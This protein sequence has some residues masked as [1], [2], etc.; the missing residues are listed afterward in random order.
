[1]NVRKEFSMKKRIFGKSRGQIAVL[2]AGII[3]VLLGAVALGADVAVMYVKWQQAQKVADVAAL[4]GANYLAGGVTYADST[5]GTAYPT[6]SGCNGES[7]G[8]TSAEIATQVA[9][10]YAV[11][12]GLPASTVTISEPASEIKVVATETGLPYFFAKTLGMSTYSVSA[13]A[14]AQAPGP[15][16]TVALSRGCSRL[17]SNALHHARRAA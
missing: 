7:S 1:V 17:D 10:T 2:Y 4:A 15:V 9:C 12:N 6:A 14:A 3:A 8:T 11:N 16:D 13:A 5:T